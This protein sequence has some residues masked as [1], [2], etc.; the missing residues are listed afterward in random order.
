MMI[1]QCL[2]QALMPIGIACVLGR[3]D[4]GL[5]V[6]FF[7]TFAAGVLSG[8]FTLAAGTVEE[9]GDLLAMS[10]HGA[11]LFRL[12]KILSGTLFPLLLAVLV[13]FGLLAAREPGYAAA[14]FFAALPLGFASSLCAETFAQP[15]KPGVRPKLMADPL[16]MIPL[17]GTQIISGT[18]AGGCVFAAE[19]S[20]SML[21]VALVAS[22]LVLL[23]AVG[24]AQLRKPMF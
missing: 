17:L 13:S 19:L 1:V 6:A 5:A 23:I 12:G 20:G 3:D 7:F 15:V 18:I 16:M 2:A 4:V 9:C 8:M 21:A 24:L 11:R 10:P 22:Y 14:V